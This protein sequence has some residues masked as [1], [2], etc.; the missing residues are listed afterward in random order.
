MQSNQTLLLFLYFN[1]Q[2][3]AT[4]IDVVLYNIQNNN[5]EIKEKYSM[6]HSINS[7]DLD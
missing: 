7:G 2:K 6:M 5:I 1:D 4:V 3:I